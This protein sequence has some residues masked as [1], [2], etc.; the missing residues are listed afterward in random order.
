MLDPNISEMGSGREIGLDLKRQQRT[1]AKYRTIM[2]D[3]ELLVEL[4]PS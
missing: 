2:A 1:V 4:E 3:V